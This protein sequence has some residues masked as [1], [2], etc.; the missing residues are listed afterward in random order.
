MKNREEIMNEYYKNVTKEQLIKDI[1]KAGM[2]V[3][4]KNEFEEVREM[5]NECLFTGRMDILADIARH[6]LSQLQSEKPE[7]TI[8]ELVAKINEN[9]NQDYIE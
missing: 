1:E 9:N 5:I 2:I 7:H 3:K 4:E 8:G 6:L